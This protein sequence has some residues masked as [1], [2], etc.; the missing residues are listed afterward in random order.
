MDPIEEFDSWAWGEH[1]NGLGYKARNE[2]DRVKFLILK[3]ISFLKMI[4][5][6]SHPYPLFFDIRNS[7]TKEQ[8]VLNP[9]TAGTVHC[10]NY[11]YSYPV[12]I[13]IKYPEIAG[14]KVCQGNLLLHLL[15]TDYQ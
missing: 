11:D 6:L 8:C 5:F 13:C 1:P 7:L 4:I 14:L 10:R 12:D 9:T 3:K 2:G 15:G